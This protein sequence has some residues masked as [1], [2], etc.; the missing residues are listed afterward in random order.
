MKQ[1]SALLL[2]TLEGPTSLTSEACT[3]AMAL[4]FEGTEYESTY[5]GGLE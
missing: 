1:W 3:V 4:L 5:L 2:S